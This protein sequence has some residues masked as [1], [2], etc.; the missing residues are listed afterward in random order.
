MKN[1]DKTLIAALDPGFNIKVDDTKL[2]VFEFSMNHHNLIL[3]KDCRWWIEEQWLAS[4]ASMGFC[5]N[6][7]VVRI[8]TNPSK[9][10]KVRPDGVLL[11]DEGGI[12]GQLVTGPQFGC[13]HGQGRC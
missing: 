3:C 11:D 6:E 2:L 1:Y 8:T 13:I 5:N 9:N 4:G 10:R 7:M 12:T